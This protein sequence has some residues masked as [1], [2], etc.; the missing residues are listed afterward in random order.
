MKKKVPEMEPKTAEIFDHSLLDEEA[1]HVVFVL[2]PCDD[3]SQ[4]RARD[5]EQAQD[6]V[7]MLV[8]R[9]CD[10]DLLDTF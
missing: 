1:G 2:D 8:D 4:L 5:P 9:H 3:R 7:R 10:H 6:I